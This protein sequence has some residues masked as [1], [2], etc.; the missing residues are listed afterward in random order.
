MRAVVL[1]GGLL[2]IGTTVAFA[3][4]TVVTGRYTLTPSGAGFV[5]LD[6]QTGQVSECTG[7]P[8]SLVCKSTPDERTALMAEIDRLQGKIDAWDAAAPAPAVDQKSLELNIPDDRQVDKAFN[9]L[10]RMIKRFK[11][12]VEEM[13]KEPSQSTP[14]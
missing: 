1:I 6:T 10:E 5:R 4:D 12:L 2:A 14:L 7:A 8:S 13:R 11:G 3:A 9:F